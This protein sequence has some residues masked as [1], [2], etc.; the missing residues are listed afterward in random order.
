M[1][2]GPHEAL[3]LSRP[4]PG[5]G[6]NSFTPTPP[7]LSVICKNVFSSLLHSYLGAFYYDWTLFGAEGV[8]RSWGILLLSL[9]WAKNL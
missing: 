4:R 1:V 2:K 7:P 5:T 3:I 8:S 6:G 9:F